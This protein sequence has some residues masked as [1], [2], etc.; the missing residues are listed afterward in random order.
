M[1][2][3]PTAATRAAATPRVATPHRPTLDRPLR[4]SE[5]AGNLDEG[6]E[7]LIGPCFVNPC[8]PHTSSM[9]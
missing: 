4:E 6:E 5:S 3:L 8:D 7:A 2:V 1:P 9:I